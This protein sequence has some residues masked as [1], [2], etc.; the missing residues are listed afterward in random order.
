MSSQGQASEELQF[1]P[2]ALRDKYQ[3]ERDKRLRDDGNQQYQEMSGEFDHYTDD[4]YVENVIER[5]SLK[6]SVEIVIVGGG[7]GGLLLLRYLFCTTC[8]L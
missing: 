2:D 3:Q 6:D 7:F 8:S 5:E 4:P 1:D